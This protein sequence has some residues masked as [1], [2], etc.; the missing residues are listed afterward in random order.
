MRKQLE[1][2]GLNAWIEFLGE[3]RRKVRSPA[4]SLALSRLPPP[5]LTV[6]W[7]ELLGERRRKVH[8]LR[9]VLVALS[10]DYPLIAT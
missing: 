5:S 6:P 9:R 8:M 4:I 7:I 10:L 1:R 3:R 2:K